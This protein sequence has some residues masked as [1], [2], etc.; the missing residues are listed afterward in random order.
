MCRY[1][2]RRP[3]R[4][5]LERPVI[6]FTFDDFP[7]SAWTNGGRILQEHGVAGT[8]YT[9]LE[10]M[11]RQLDAGPGFKAADLTELLAAGHELGCHTYAHCPSWE[12]APADFERSIV[13]NREALHKIL[14]GTNFRSL[15]WP[16]NSPRPDTK[17]RAA[18]Y[19]DACRGG[20]QGFNTGIVDLNFLNSFFI[21]QSVNNP[22]VIKDTIKR[23]VSAN[24]WL[25]F[26]THDVSPAPTRLGCKPELFAEIVQ[27]AVESGAE[28]LT[29]GRALDKIGVTKTAASAEPARAKAMPVTAHSYKA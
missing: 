13:A 28:V 22:S 1:F 25:I 20:G 2:A 14:P 18:R 12:T 24:G 16:I 7:H 17:R 9:A 26:S 11:D 5:A 23:S 8:Y 21:E 29:V 10:L 15:S 19:F 27:C 3:F 6:S 4:I